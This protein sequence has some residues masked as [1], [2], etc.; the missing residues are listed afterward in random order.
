MRWW[1][2]LV[3]SLSLVIIGL[4]N[5]ILN[6][7]IPTIQRELDASA[8]ELQWMVDSYVLVFAGLLLTM[9]ALGDRYGRKL[10]LQLGL[11]IFGISSIFAAYSTSSEMLIATRA[12]MGVGG[13]LIMPS[14]LSIIT[15]VFPRDERGKA[16]GIWAGTA[17]FGIGI[18]PAL[19]GWLIEQFWW[20]SVFLINGPVVLVALVAGLFLVPRS[21]DP[22]PPRIDPAGA[23]LSIA[24]LVA[25]VFA[26]IEAPSRGWL[27]PLVL[28]S[29]GLSLVLGAIFFRQELRSDHPMLNLDF[30]RNPRFSAGAGAITMAFFAMFGVIFILTQY[31]QFVQGYS[32]LQAGVRIAPFALGMMAGAANSHRLVRRFGTNKVV[33]GGLA[34]LA[35]MLTSFALWDVDTPYWVILISVILMSFGMANTMAPS[36]D[37][38][39]GAVP[40]A[41]AGVGSAMND[42]TRM[43]GGALGV[44]IIGSVLNTVYSSSMAEATA[45]LPPERADAASDSVGAAIGIG[46]AI[47]GPPGEALIA[48]AR[49]EFVGGM[50]Y[51]FFLAAAVALTGSLLVLRF[52]PAGH[53]GTQEASPPPEALSSEGQAGSGSL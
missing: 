41:K 24:T 30:F 45:G 22:V 3:L 33:S 13:A 40:L 12:V 11:V 9:G 38:V 6:V 43:V 1:T 19:G 32:A 53:L 27:D 29:F 4:D 37:A 39:M 20:G 17:A 34:L 14:T 18:G 2:L 8:S 36:T 50:G 25:L 23:V 42:T 26:I 44:A 16:I 7:A 10:T 15:D 21:R 48:A 5:T 35:I 46:G 51:A 49:A 28:A 31:L 47:G 52:M